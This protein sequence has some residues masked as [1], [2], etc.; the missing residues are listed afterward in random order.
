MRVSKVS[1]FLLAAIVFFISAAALGDTVALRNGDRITGT[2][3]GLKDGKLSIEGTAF[4]DVSV[5]FSEVDSISIESEMGIT[6]AGG[7]RAVGTIEWKAQERGAVKTASGAWDFPAQDIVEIGPAEIEPPAWHGSLELGVSGQSGNKETLRVNARVK[8][9]RESD[10]TL[11]TGYAL[12]RYSIEGGERSENLQRAGA[13]GEYNI[14][15]DVFWYAS[16]D[17]ERDEFK[18]LDLRTQASLGLGR[19]W[20][21]KGDNYWKTS[22]GIGVTHEDYD[23]DESELMPSGELMGDYGK[24]LSDT[25]VFT[26]TVKFL[27]S[28]SR[29]TSWR[30][31]N[32]AGLAV[33]LTNG[34]EWKLKLGL[35]HEYDNDPPEGT[36]TMDTYY[37]MNAVR[38]F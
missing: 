38:I 32:D 33:D 2:V 28:L 25:V 24:R 37:Y 3:T 11:L 23:D 20:W 29:I 4:G 7:S 19:W 26:D 22:A 18:D 10:G 9:K 31:T 8:L 1:G 27:P 17:F 35:A 5:D 34:G 14:T 16:V 30:A 21:K 12:G 6:L 15:P 36:D 13:R